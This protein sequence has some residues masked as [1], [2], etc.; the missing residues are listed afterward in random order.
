MR[1][2][3]GK[4][5]KS[6][7]N[8]ENIRK[9]EA[10]DSEDAQTL[11][12]AKS[13]CTPG[14]HRSGNRKMR[15]KRKE[16]S[17]KGKIPPKLSEPPRTCVGGRH[18]SSKSSHVVPCS[19]VWAWRGGRVSLVGARGPAGGSRGAAGAQT[20]TGHR[21]AVMAALAEGLPVLEPLLPVPR[22]KTPVPLTTA[23]WYRSTGT[24]TRD[25]I[26]III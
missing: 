17:W 12:Q 5:R 21:W 1:E 26:I 10:R 11:P 9:I 3:E 8:Q 14:R 22:P 19:W 20:L 4:L 16:N 13:S 6:K 25:I 2:H 23:Y 24:G 15:K 18:F 7:E